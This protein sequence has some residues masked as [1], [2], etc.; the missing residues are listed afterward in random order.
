MI[1]FFRRALSSWLVLGLFGLVL[2]AFAVTSIDPSWI[3][4]SNSSGPQLA[5]V[6]R[7]KVSATETRQRIDN[8]LRQAQQQ[9]PQ[10]DMAGFAA[11]GAIDQIIDQAIAFRAL[12][13]WGRANGLGVSDRLIDGEI[14]STPAFFG[15]TG[16][17]DRTAMENAL[18]QARISERQY[19]TDI[20]GDA[21][22]RQLF[23]PIAFG[24]RA[25]DALLM[26]NASLLLEQ[27]T[28]LIGI[29]P[30]EAIPAG[31]APTDPEI[32]AF[33]KA[34][35]A[36]FTIPERRVLRYAI[37]GQDNLPGNFT[38]TEAEIDAFYKAN[39]ATYAANET[40]SIAQV[41]LSDQ[42][43]AAALVAKVKAG[44]PIADAAK[45]AGVE[46]LTSDVA[47]AKLAE[48]AS[49]AIADAAFTQPQGGVAGPIKGDLGWYVVQ[50]AKIN[51]T[52]GRSL[53]AVRAEIAESLTKQKRD[54]TLA[55]LVSG[56]E[57]E[58]AD[59]ASFDDVVKAKKLVVATTP[60]IL[61]DGRAPDQPAWQAPP[62]VAALMR[63]AS[64]MTT[65]DD[66]T[67]ETIGA[68]RYALM[69]VSQ[70]VPATPAPLTDVRE[71]VIAGIRSERTAKQA[72]AIADAIL[73]KAKAG[74]PLAD[75]FAQAGV[76]L[77]APTKAAARQMDLLRQDRP[78]PPPLKLM[79]GM[80]KGE[81]RLI[82]APNNAGWFVV[83]LGDVIAGDAKTEP[84]LVNSLRGGFSRNIGD[85]YLQQFV[86]AASKDVGVQRN[87]PAINALKAE[88]GGQ[89]R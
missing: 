65:E 5:T 66:P 19:R 58:I 53:A 57:D 45:Q 48:S 79:F 16:R 82:A 30:S 44:T 33:Y 64:Q 81:T 54:E 1:S 62:E 20:A 26:A 35:I 14:A 72:R 40:R 74:T 41:I 86:A 9:N 75:A 60:A 73:A 25:P 11:Q 38:P 89:G 22:R 21:L 85:E 12:E 24:A 52:A 88:L 27:R 28:G 55:S 39:A 87:A 84:A 71:A 23:V 77:P 36:R 67:V 78:A 76:R 46:A 18:N 63:S 51:A 43:A 68:E 32:Q 31:P 49:A 3:N 7:S 80:K 69:Q 2:I 8:A 6:G 83:Q 4:G 42:K 56:V 61:T 59:G 29:V 70:V 34:N 50:V 37:F 10:L 15:L 17:F 13:V 47:K